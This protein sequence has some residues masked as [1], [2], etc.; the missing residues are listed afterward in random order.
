VSGGTENTTFLFGGGYYRESTVFPGSNAF[1]RASANLNVNHSS[2]D[3]RFQTAIQLLYNS[4]FSDIPGIDLTSLAISLAPNAP[5]LYDNDGDLNWENGTWTNPLA[6][7]KRTY[8]AKTD[9]LIANASAS[10]LIL[11]GLTVKSTFGYNTMAVE[12]TLINPLAAYNPQELLGRTGSSNFGNNSIRTWIIEPQLSF[13]QNIGRSTFAALVGTTFQQSGQASRTLSAVGYTNDALLQNVAAATDVTVLSSLET[14]YR[15]TAL[16]SR[17]NYN[18]DNRYIVNLTGR[19]DGSSRFGPGNRFANFGAIG[20]AWIFTNE[21]FFP[22]TSALPFGKLRVSYGSTGSD[23]I[24]NYQYLDTYTPTT[25]PYDN[26]SSL[27]VNRLRNP[28]YSWETNKKFEVGLDINLLKNALSFSSSYYLNRSSNQLVGLPLPAVTGQTTVQFNLPATV[29]N[30][31]LEFLI[32]ASV[33]KRRNFQWDTDM[34]ITLPRNRLIDF[35]GLEKFPAYKNRFEIGKS[36]FAFKAMEFEGVDP[37]TGLY[38]FNDINDDGEVNS[39]TDLRALTNLTQRYYGGINN[40]FRYRSISL[41]VFVQFV[42]QRGYSAARSFSFP[43][44][45]SNQP[46]YVMSRWQKEGDQ[47]EIQRFTAFDPTGEVTA[48]YA[49]NIFS[50]NAVT[51]ASFIRLKNI[52]LSWTLPLEWRKVAKLEEARF[53]VNAQNV[54]TFTDYV[55]LD[56]ETQLSQTLPPLRMITVGVQVTL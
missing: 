22:K 15:Y 54:F 41:D 11:P 38:Q 46:D 42:N 55:G 49:N 24:G 2:S 33:F 53:Y 40:S 32:T 34:N 51:D 43:G 7:L 12:E 30:E 29:Q 8:D 39:S 10:Y 18:W 56:P 14:D 35:P 28:Q 37:Q 6:F 27:R 1:Q 5:A 26:Q 25:Y 4:S 3:Q 17:I 19:R 44:D 48:A 47:T 9:N 36:L 45:F 21:T 31:G 13:T 52:S 16:F 20:I 50:N 23:A